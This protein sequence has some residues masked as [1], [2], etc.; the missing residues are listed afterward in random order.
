MRHYFGPVFPLSTGA[1]QSR[2]FCARYFFSFRLQVP[3]VAPFW[4]CQLFPSAPISLINLCSIDLFSFLFNTHPRLHIRLPKPIIVLLAHFGYSI[5]SK[6]QNRKFIEWNA[7][8]LRSAIATPFILEIYC[9]SVQ[10]GRH[11]LKYLKKNHFGSDSVSSWHTP[12]SCARILHPLINDHYCDNDIQRFKETL[13][14]ICY[15][16]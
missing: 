10:W 16:V 3:G 4:T 1:Y 11:C 9:F 14:R 12:S 13:R 15:L 5:D 2:H 7:K 6:F 8:S